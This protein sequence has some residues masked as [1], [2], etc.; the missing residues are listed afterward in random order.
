MGRRL[1]LSLS[2]SKSPKYSAGVSGVSSSAC[3]SSPITQSKSRRGRAAVFPNRLS[4]LAYKRP[5]LGNCGPVLQSKRGSLLLTL[6]G[7]WLSSML[8]LPF[9]KAL[10]QSHSLNV[11]SVAIKQAVTAMK[12]PPK[13]MATIVKS[14]PGKTKFENKRLER[15]QAGNYDSVL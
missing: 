5:S 3:S 7:R 4:G 10:L 1:A 9:L 8:S 11:Q 2:L 13:E 14:A 15:R 12:V 6:S